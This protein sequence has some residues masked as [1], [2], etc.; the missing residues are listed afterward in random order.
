MEGAQQARAV[1]SGSDNKIGGLLEMVQ[2]CEFQRLVERHVHWSFREWRHRRRWQHA[3][4]D[5]RFDP[6]TQPL[7]SLPSGHDSERVV[8]IY[9]WIQLAWPDT[10][11]RFRRVPTLDY[12][13]SRRGLVVAFVRVMTGDIPIFTGAVC[14]AAFLLGVEFHFDWSVFSSR[15]FGFWRSL[16][17]AYTF[18]PLLMPAVSSTTPRLGDS[19][20]NYFVKTRVS[21]RNAP[22]DLRCSA[23]CNIQPA[24][25]GDMFTSNKI[26]QTRVMIPSHSLKDLE[27]SWEFPNIAPGRFDSSATTRVHGR[28]VS[29]AQKKGVR[30]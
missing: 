8:P 27:I 28:A 18:Y 1:D 2:S 29:L 25:V 26:S 3:R 4:G 13:G 14:L 10:L 6:S 16:K 11:N 9:N 19:D 12:K 15:V 5:R 23:N 17:C 30:L 7:R 20:G 24:V 22:S 21:H